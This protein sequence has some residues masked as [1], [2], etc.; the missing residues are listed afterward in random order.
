[1]KPLLLSSIASLALAST[2]LANDIA[3]TAPL[4]ASSLHAGRLDM[5]A[6]R[7]DL[8]DGAYEVTA[9]FRAR[10]DW[11]QPQ[12]VMMRLEDRDEVHFSMPSD[13]QTLYTFAASFGAVTISAKEL[14]AEHVAY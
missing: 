4:E 7:T 2:A 1:M 6:Y 13:P 3:L 8:P 9:V 10:N 12:R 11:D 5:V 14:P